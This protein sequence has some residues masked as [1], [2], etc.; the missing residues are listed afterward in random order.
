V[1]LET[2]EIITQKFT[3]GSLGGHVK[4]AAIPT[5]ANRLSLKQVW[6]RKSLPGFG[7]HLFPRIA[8]AASVEPYLAVG[9][10]RGMAPIWRETQSGWLGFI[11]AGRKREEFFKKC[12]LG[13]ILQVCHPPGFY[14]RAPGGWGEWEYVET[15]WDGFLGN[16]EYL[17]F[18]RRHADRLAVK[19]TLF[20]M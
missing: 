10:Q 15:C 3:G 1:R 19:G 5:E 18:V 9:E 17:L 16:E 14:G 4:S 12:R 7:E 20:E 2:G 11:L 6:L 13:Q 8:S